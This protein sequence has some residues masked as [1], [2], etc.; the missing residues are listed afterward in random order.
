MTITSR[1]NPLS[2][3]SIASPHKYIPYDNRCMSTIT[4]ECSPVYVNE[5]LNADLPILDNIYFVSSHDDL[6][7]PTTSSSNTPTINYT[8]L[9]HTG[10]IIFIVNVSCEY[11]TICKRRKEAAKPNIFRTSSIQCRLL[12]RYGGMLHFEK[13]SNNEVA[14]NLDLNPDRLHGNNSIQILNQIIISTPE[15]SKLSIRIAECLDE[16]VHRIVSSNI[17]NFNCRSY[18]NYN[19]SF[20]LEPNIH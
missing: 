10:V 17:S 1:L 9:I 12:H 16:I 7:T 20:F 5:D 4:Y 15:N 19:F 14:D 8:K 2:Y 13:H 18:I 3:I 6:D 11:E